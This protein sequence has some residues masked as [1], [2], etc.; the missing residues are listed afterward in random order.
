[1]SHRFHL[2]VDYLTTHASNFR[3]SP[4]VSGSVRK[5][6]HV[7]ACAFFSVARPWEIRAA[8]VL[9]WVLSSSHRTDWIL[10]LTSSHI[11]KPSS[12]DGKEKWKKYMK[13][14]GYVW[15]KSYSYTSTIKPKVDFFL[16][17]TCFQLSTIGFACKFWVPKFSYLRRT[18]SN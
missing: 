2:L 4:H 7:C 13:I 5:R 6:R 18:Q 10:P 11:P 17:G 3:R 14:S 16:V 9:F 8:V 12:L 15:T 1:M